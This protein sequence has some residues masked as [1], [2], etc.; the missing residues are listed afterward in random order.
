M[1][2]R[3]SASLKA[4]PLNERVSLGILQELDVS[5]RVEE[6]ARGI[7]IGFRKSTPHKIVSSLLTITNQDVKLT[8]LWGS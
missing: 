2:C 3:G 7:S 5:E 4:A 6:T 8:V 1:S